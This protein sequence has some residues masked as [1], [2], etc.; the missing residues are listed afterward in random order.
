M[1]ANTAKVLV[2]EAVKI[3][4]GEYVYYQRGHCDR[5]GDERLVYYDPTEK[6]WKYC[7][8]CWRNVGRDATLSLPADTRADALSMLCG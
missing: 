8:D 4:T 3:V 7:A 5:C 1:D 2:T 6:R